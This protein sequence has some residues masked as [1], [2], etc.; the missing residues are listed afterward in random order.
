MMD[1]LSGFACSFSGLLPTVSRS[2]M[3]PVATCRALRGTTYSLII[4]LPSEQ[5]P[6]VD[7]CWDGVVDGGPQLN[8]H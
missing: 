6:G 7:G 3:R 2:T 5:T 8:Q 1:F 4:Y